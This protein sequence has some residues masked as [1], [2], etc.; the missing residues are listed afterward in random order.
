MNKEIKLQSLEAGPFT[1]SQNRMTFEIPNDGVYDMSSSY[2]NLN[3][4]VSVTENSVAEG[5]GIYPMDVVINSN[6]G[7]F[8]Q[9]QNSALVKNCMLRSS[10]LGNIENIRRSDQLQ[11]V[12]YTLNKSYHQKSSRSYNALSQ[13]SQPVNV[14]KYTIYRD[15]NKVGIVKSKQNNISPVKIKLADLFDFCSQAIELDTTKT[16]VITCMLELNIN[17]L[18]AIQNMKDDDWSPDLKNSFATVNVQGEA[19]TIL[20]TL[21]FT[22]LDQSPFYVGQKLKVSATGGNG[23]P[24]VVDKLAVIDQ[25]VWNA[26]GTLSITFEQKWGDIGAGEDYTDIEVATEDVAAA[27][28]NLNFGEVVLHKLAMDKSDFSQIEY[29]TFSTEQTN[30]NGLTNYQNQFQVEG[31]SDAVIIAFP[32]DNDIISNNDNVQSYRLRLDNHDLTDRDV[33]LGSPLYYDRLNMGMTQMKLKLRDLALNLRNTTDNDTL[34]AVRDNDTV[35][36][37]IVAPLEQKVQ[38]KLLQLNVKAANTGVKQISIFK[39]IPRV[40]EY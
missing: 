38:E 37:T 18:L 14:G 27:T 16:G 31:Q 9:Y 30:G 25:I 26:N 7:N 39:H 35:I 6:G 32:G 24:N 13:I 3:V 36:Y 10:K 29:S 11:S 17:K 15:I 33:I 40:L 1:A 19:N 12:I 4:E 8:P 34:D 21:K 2:I 23:A 28:V 22:N 5:I 20:T